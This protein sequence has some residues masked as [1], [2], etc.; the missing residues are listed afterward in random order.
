MDWAC[1][2]V[3]SHHFLERP[4]ISNQD[5]RYHDRHLNLELPREQYV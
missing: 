2:E 4:E 3:L 5:R 1:L